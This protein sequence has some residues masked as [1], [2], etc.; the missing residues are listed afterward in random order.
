MEE[1]I[2]NPV[3]FIDKNYDESIVPLYDRD[4]NRIIKRHQGSSHSHHSSPREHIRKAHWHTFRD[5]S[6]RW[7]KAKVINK[8]QGKVLYDL[9]ISKKGGE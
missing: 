7:V 1:Y 3:Y 8:G 4:L 9:R 5:G 6:V 2:D